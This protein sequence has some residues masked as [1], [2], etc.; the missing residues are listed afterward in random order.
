MKSWI[1]PKQHGEQQR[2]L[3]FLIICCSEV[4][5]DKVSFSVAK[6]EPQMSVS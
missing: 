4:E 6:S 3:V 1:I 5:A 2:A